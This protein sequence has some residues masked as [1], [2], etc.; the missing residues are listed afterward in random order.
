MYVLHTGLHAGLLLQTILDGS[1]AGVH[2]ETGGGDPVGG[3]GIYQEHMGTGHIFRQR[4]TV[5]FS[6]SDHEQRIHQDPSFGQHNSE[7]SVQ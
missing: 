4:E 3:I 5:V 1:P 2:Q 6:H 7:H